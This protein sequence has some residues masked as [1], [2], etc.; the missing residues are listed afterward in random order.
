MI[1]S[2]SPVQLAR[3][4]FA[5]VS[6]AATVPARAGILYSTGFEEPEFLPGVA[7]GQNEWVNVIGNKKAVIS[8]TNPA[9]GSQDLRIGSNDLAPEGAALVSTYRPDLAVFHVDPA[10]TPLV[11]FQVEA[12][13]DGLLL[14]NA[15]NHAN[16]LI[17]SAAFVGDTHS[18]L[19]EMYISCDGH[20]YADNSLGQYLL[21]SSATTGRYYQ[22]GMLIDFQHLT[23]ELF[24]NGSFLGELPVP[25][26]ASHDVL[27]D[28]SMFVGTPHYSD[29]SASFDD[30][31]IESMHTVPEPG[32]ATLLAL[33][34][35]SLGG[36]VRLCRRRFKQL[37]REDS[38]ITGGICSN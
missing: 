3:L 15:A 9:S 1:Q 12:R 29:Y 23:S 26:L 24:L 2:P 25:A 8:T 14:G 13:L 31:L 37:S 5:A 11:Y 21:Q 18:I 28:L 32:S 10:V 30:Y 36:L 20:I 6:L 19:A 22:L 33:S 16:D 17:G 34:V 7:V 27:F 4:L 35:V 38:R